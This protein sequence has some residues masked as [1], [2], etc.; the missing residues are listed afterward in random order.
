MEPISAHNIIENNKTFTVNVDKDSKES[1]ASMTYT[2]NIP[3]N[4]QVYA[5]LPNIN[6]SNDD[7]KV[8]EVS[9][10]KEK[11]RFTTNNVFTFYNI[12]YFKEEFASFL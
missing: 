4:T 10:G 11:R 9:I 1:F 6:F 2:V 7:Q 5:S 12:G 8:V 3:A